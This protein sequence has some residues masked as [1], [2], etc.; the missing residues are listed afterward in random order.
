MKKKI[1]GKRILLQ[2]IEEGQDDAIKNLIIA[3]RTPEFRYRYRD[4]DKCMVKHWTKDGNSFIE[5]FF[6][7]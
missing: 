1:R 3:L 7:E 2:F 6:Q 4:M 5:I